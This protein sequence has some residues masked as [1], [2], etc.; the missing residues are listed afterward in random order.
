MRYADS[1]F[2]CP[3]NCKPATYQLIG[4]LC[5]VK[6]RPSRLPICMQS[7]ASGL[8]AP[9][10]GSKVQ[11]TTINTKRN[12]CKQRFIICVSFRRFRIILP[13]S[14][15][16]WSSLKT[17]WCLCQFD[18]SFYSHTNNWYRTSGGTCQL[19][20]RFDSI[21]INFIKSRKISR[22]NRLKYISDWCMRK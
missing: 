16:Y 18:G 20:W 21:L 10:A 7:R 14:M 15:P 11:A 8:G 17:L 3:A 6:S 9:S 5:S 13:I 1:P 2:W 22:I 12:T 4:H 19:K